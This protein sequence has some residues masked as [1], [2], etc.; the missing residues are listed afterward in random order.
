MA[1]QLVCWNHGGANPKARAAATIRI[2]SLKTLEDAEP[3][4]NIG[5]VYNELLAIAGITRQ[6]RK[7]LTER[8]AQLEELDQWGGDAGRQIKVDVIVFERALERSAKIAEMIVRLNLEERKQAL[9]E[10]LAGQVAAVVRAILLDL[11]LTPEQERQAAIVAPARLR[12]LT[13]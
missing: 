4:A 7:I 3:M 8:V 11:E 13:A 6:W 5:E 1:G 9:D 10:Q 2:L 12:E